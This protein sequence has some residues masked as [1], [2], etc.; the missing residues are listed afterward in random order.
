MQLI[1]LC[2]IQNDNVYLIMYNIKAHSLL[3]LNHSDGGAIYRSLR[4]SRALVACA[5]C[6]ILV[7][8]NNSIYD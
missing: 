3:V 4:S 6:K 8:T 7:N 1:M 2:N 5:A